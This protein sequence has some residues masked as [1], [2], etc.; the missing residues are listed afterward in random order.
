MLT[1]ITTAS[2]RLSDGGVSHDIWEVGI[3]G[4]YAFKF[5]ILFANLENIFDIRQTSYGPVVFP[6]AN[7]QLS[8]THPAFAEIYGPLE[9]RI[10]NIGVKDSLMGAFAKNGNKD[11]GV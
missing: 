6:N 1:A 3:G 4:Q 2:V 5:L 8:Y 9:G 7:P 11:G 10:L